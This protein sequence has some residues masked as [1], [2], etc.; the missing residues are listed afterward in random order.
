MK[1]LSTYAELKPLYDVALS[2]YY[3]MNVGSEEAN[4]AIAS[5]NYYE[6]KLESIEVNSKLFENAA[7]NL[8]FATGAA[9]IYEVLAE[10]VQYY[11]YTDAT[12]SSKVATAMQ[13]YEAKV[14]EYN[15]QVETI[16]AEI[17]LATQI[18]ASLRAD[19]VP[20]AILAIVNE[21]YESN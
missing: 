13:T 4:A 8:K 1:A 6:D 16:N 12:Y 19:Q 2:Y 20:V 21:Y 7:V 17:E 5:F 11:E 14:A 9:A 18:V 10:C 15:S 3:G